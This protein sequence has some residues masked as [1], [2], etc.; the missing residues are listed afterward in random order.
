MGKSAGQKGVNRMKF[1]RSLCMADR[2]KMEELAQRNPYLSGAELLQIREY[3]AN[4]KLRTELPVIGA[5]VIAPNSCLTSQ[6]LEG[7]RCGIITGEWDP[8]MHNTG[9]LL[10]LSSILDQISS[11]E[12]SSSR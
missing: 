3:Y 1:V 6:L 9:L 10:T 12:Y 2:C 7:N 5:L 8:S 11:I 4:E